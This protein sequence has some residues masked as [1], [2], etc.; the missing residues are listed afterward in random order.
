MTCRFSPTYRL[1]TKADYTAVFNE[2]LKISQTWFL[3]LYKK[4]NKAYPRIGIIV[5][6]RVVK[7]ASSRNRL[8]RLI[9]EGFRTRKAA[10]QGLDLVILAREGCKIVDNVKL[11][12]ELDSL[13]QRLGH[14]S[15][16]LSSGSTGTSS[17]PG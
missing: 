13:W 4:N 12:K 1:T 5:S 3:A 16:S 14:N 8:K 11:Q 15:S 6:K 9:R 10:L 7:K 2:R 17:V